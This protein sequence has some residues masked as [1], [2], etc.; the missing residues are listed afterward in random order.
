MSAFVSSP[1]QY[2]PK[3]T[4]AQASDRPH[5]DL[6]PLQP[7]F[8]HRCYRVRSTPASTGAHCSAAIRI[9]RL[10]DIGVLRILDQY[11]DVLLCAG[12]DSPPRPEDAPDRKSTRLNSS[13]ANIS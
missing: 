9:E 8:L 11:F 7:L 4:G 6:A 12:A 10:F 5:R 1:V 13:H 2:R 3:R